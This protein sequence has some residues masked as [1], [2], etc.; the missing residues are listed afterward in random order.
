MLITFGRVPLFFYLLHFYLIKFLSIGFA[1]LRYGRADWLYG[2]PRPD[3]VPS[4]NGYDLWVV[5]LVWLG[6]VLFLYPLCYW[7]AGVKA[8][9]RSAWLSYF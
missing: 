7:F 8:R 3:A 4:D 5:Y 9:S 6:V 2:N 1:F